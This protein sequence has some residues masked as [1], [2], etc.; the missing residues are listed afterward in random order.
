MD[1]AV[2]YKALSCFCPR[3]QLKPF[4]LS[5]IVTLFRSSDTI[6]P[7]NFAPN[8]AR[9]QRPFTYNYFYMDSFADIQLLLAESCSGDQFFPDD[10]FKRFQE[11]TGIIPVDSDREV[12]DY[13]TY[14][15]IA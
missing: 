8:Y 14:C 11:S 10:T 2:R 15:V 9:P 7:V 3:Y 5:D 6:Y 4:H 13:G 12:P 1:P